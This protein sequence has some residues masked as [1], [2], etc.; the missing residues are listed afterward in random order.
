[1]DKKFIDACMYVKDRMEEV[2]SPDKEMVGTFLLLS[3]RGKAGRSL[4]CLSMDLHRPTCTD[5]NV[6]LCATRLFSSASAVLI[7]LQ[8]E[9]A[10]G[11][12]L[13]F[14]LGRF[15]S[16]VLNNLVSSAISQA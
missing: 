15:G 7:Y 12:L 3:E 11:S 4:V 2:S 8:N 1:M 10:A 9:V 5:P 13:T 16:T 6:Q 14:S